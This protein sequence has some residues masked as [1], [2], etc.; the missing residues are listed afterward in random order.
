MMNVRNEFIK[1]STLEELKKVYRAFALKFHPDRGGDVEIMKQINALYDE[2]FAKVKDIHKNAKGETYTKENT[3][4]AAQFKDIIDK[5][6]RMKGVEVEVIGCFI[7]LSGNTKEHKDAIKEM[8]FKWHSKK[9]MWYKSPEDYH[10]RG[11]KQYS[12]DEIRDMYGTSGKM[13]GNAN[14]LLQAGA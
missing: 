6:L 1:V 11:K 9:K 13:Y 2:M 4:T 5:L 12:M 8:G 14:E 3:E 10:R 7:W